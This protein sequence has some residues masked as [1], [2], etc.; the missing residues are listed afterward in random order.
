MKKRYWLFKRAGI[1]Y[2]QDVES[3]KKESL[4]TSDRKEAER[5]REARN[6]A[7]QRPHLGLTLAKAYLTAYDPEMLES[8]WTTVLNA[9]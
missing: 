2:L 1:Y 8:T 4:H 6:E 7:A 5:L 3:R 9:F